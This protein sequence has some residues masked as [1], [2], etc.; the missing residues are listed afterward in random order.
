MAKLDYKKARSEGYSDEE[1]RQ[2][3]SKNPDIELTNAPIR[4]MGAAE[5]ASATD[6]AARG[7]LAQIPPEERMAF[8][9]S[10]EGQKMFREPAT[11]KSAVAARRQLGLLPFVGAGLGLMTGPA[12]PV[13]TPLLTAGGKALEQRLLMGRGL[14]PE[15]GLASQFFMEDPA[16]QTAR[17]VD[18]AESLLLGGGAGLVKQAA[19][20]MIAARGARQLAKDQIAKAGGKF[21]ARE[22]PPYR[23]FEALK[24][25]GLLGGLTKGAGK[26]AGK[27]AAGKA[28]SRVVR[29]QAPAAEAVGPRVTKGAAKAR[30]AKPARVSKV[31]SKKPDLKVVKGGK[32][33]KEARKLTE[34]VIKEGD[35]IPAKNVPQSARVSPRG[36]TPGGENVR[37]NVQYYSESKKTNVHIED[38]NQKNIE[39]AINK[40]LRKR[41]TKPLTDLQAKQLAA[42]L[43]ESRHR[44]GDKG[45]HIGF[46]G[47]KG[48]RGA[49]LTAEEVAK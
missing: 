38:M 23:W 11:G 5:R 2:F 16:S 13:A 15:P 18:V 49:L 47:A 35:N 37:H 31:T 6:I 22:I 36:K 12:A 29:P 26:A 9:Q 46:S 32:P 24:E 10:P 44:L 20:K 17:N 41:A 48:T 27:R 8:L 33:D 21:L 42:L 34:Q 30:T 28:A 1:I 4:G 43:R 7:R 14:E 39:F 19:G 3:A 40:L 45:I 25:S